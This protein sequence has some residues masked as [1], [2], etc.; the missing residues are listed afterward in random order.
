MFLAAILIDF[1]GGLRAC[2]L[3]NFKLGLHDMCIVITYS[4]GIALETII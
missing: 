1:A 3:M 2:E 4:R